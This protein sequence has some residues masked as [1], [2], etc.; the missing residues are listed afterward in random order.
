MGMS[1]PLWRDRDAAGQDLA[2]ALRHWAG[3]ARNTTVIGLP[4]GGVAVAATVAEQL[5]LPLCSWAVRKLARPSAPEYAVGAIASGGCVVWNP[6]AL[7]DGSLDAQEQQHLID[8]ATPELERRA[9]LFGDPAAD[10]LQG[11]RLLVI[12]D[13][14]ATGMTVRAA[15]QSLRSCEPS[16]LVLAVP[17]LDR[18]LL[19]Q[20]RPL[21]DVLIATAIVDRLRAV[22]AFY[23]DFAQLDDLTV[24][25]LLQAARIRCAPN[26]KRTAE[27]V[28][29]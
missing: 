17:V 9:E 20:L 5:Q 8:S 21:V 24:I 12:D 10:R 2:L 13:G 29:A 6:A 28:R 18:S 22:G 4:R 1:L 15:L 14:I 27:A 16:Q 26:T 3:Q 11:R 25:R 7:I 23:E 19:P